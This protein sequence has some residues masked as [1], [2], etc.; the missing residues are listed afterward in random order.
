[1]IRILGL[2]GSPVREGNTEALLETALRRVSNDPGV[3]T[4]TI[5]LSGLDIARCSHCN[6][7]I[8]NQT[9]EKFCAISD[10][11]DVIYPAVAE[12]EVLILATPVHIGRMSGLMADMIDRLRVFVYGNF[13]RGK[14]KDK[15]GAALVVAFLRHGGLEATLNLLNSTFCLFNMI[16]VGKG[17][18]VLT[19]LDGKGKVTRG[20]RHMALEDEFGV[21]T[22]EEVVARAVELARI[23]QAGKKALADQPS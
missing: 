17:G 11:M 20:V 14:L 12:S 10:G 3:Q 23:V 15:I 5:N 4:R 18:L 6:W 13:H 21:A 16:S 8:K 2:A 9:A 1:M 19:S 7:C 22:A